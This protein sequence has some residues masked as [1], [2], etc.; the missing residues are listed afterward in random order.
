LTGAGMT[1]R[2][3][4]ERDL[5]PTPATPTAAPRTTTSEARVMK[6]AGEDMVMLV[7]LSLEGW[8]LGRLVVEWMWV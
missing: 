8:C 6:A 4:E 5:S 7:G 1:F 3:W 2:Y